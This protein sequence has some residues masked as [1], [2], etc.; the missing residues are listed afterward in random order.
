[1]ISVRYRSSRLIKLL[2]QEEAQRADAG[3]T[4]WAAWTRFLAD[5]LP[6]RE[7]AIA[8]RIGTPVPSSA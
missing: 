3:G 8:D 4:A 6:Q 7:A 2:D 5:E 1:V